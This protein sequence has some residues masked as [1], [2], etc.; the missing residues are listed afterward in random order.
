[1]RRHSASHSPHDSAHQFRLVEQHSPAAALIHGLGGAAKVEV[2]AVRTD[3][4]QPLCV[5]R[6]AHRIRPQQ[7]GPH[8]H[9]GQGEPSPH[10]FGHEAH[11]STLRQ[12]SVGHPDELAHAAVKAAGARQHVAQRSVQQAFHGR[13]QQFHVS[14]IDRPETG[15]GAE[16]SRNSP[17]RQR[18]NKRSILSVPGHPWPPWLAPPLRVRY[19]RPQ[20]KPRGVVACAR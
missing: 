19:H 9:T 8:R 7:L 6:Q 12:Q 15:N 1:M 17:G 3:T 5:F 18:Q 11:K 2:D 14:V 13:K 16:W 20:T 10:Q 4:G